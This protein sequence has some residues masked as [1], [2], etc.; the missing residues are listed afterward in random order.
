[1]N[2][3]KIAKSLID[4]LTD[5]LYYLYYSYHLYYRR[6]LHFVHDLHYLYFSPYLHHLHKLKLFVLPVIIEFTDN[7][8]RKKVNQSPT[9]L[10]TNLNSRD[11]SA[12]KNGSW[13]T[14]RC[15]PAGRYIERQEAVGIISTQAIA[16]TT[17]L[18][19]S[20]L[21]WEMFIQTWPDWLF[22]AFCKYL[23]DNNNFKSDFL[24]C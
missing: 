20:C 12:S 7:L 15:S 11:A 17:T 3:W 19:P 16:V 1:M 24:F 9:H 23:Q 6:Y 14:W 8:K 2:N 13:P 22:R 10:L 4:W 18:R 5:N 21:A